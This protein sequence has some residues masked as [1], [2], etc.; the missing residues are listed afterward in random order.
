MIPNRVLEWLAERGYGTLTSSQPVSGGCINNGMHLFM[1]SGQSF[2]LKT[3]SN[4]PQDAFQLESEGL[5]ALRKVGGPRVPE[6]LLV[7]TDFL[8]ME[9]LKPAP[10]KKEFWSDLGR[11][12]A[13]LHGFT[14]DRFGFEHDN[15]LG[16][17]PQPNSWEEDGYY[18]FIEHRLMFQVRLAFNNN[19]FQAKEIQLAERL[20]QR[21][22]ELVPEQP[23]S[24]LHGDLWGGNVISDHEGNPA[25][26]DPAV[27]FGW[28]EAELGMTALFGGFTDVF[29][30]SYE[31]VRPLE[32]GWRERLPIYNLYHLLNH[33]NL[34]GQ[35]YY[36]N[37][38]QIL[39][40]FS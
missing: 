39:G 2:F 8:L 30:K 4:L 34:F 23:A 26:I 32:A 37:A 40:R 5:N 24:L 22:T 10:K 18:F 3:N 6:T 35:G 7:G 16:S 19:F 12:L 28:G 20:C 15:Y 13:A 31:E 9:D 14:S 17:T 36:Q 21:L 25:I 33:L 1:T 27:H 29:Y 38:V 11:Q